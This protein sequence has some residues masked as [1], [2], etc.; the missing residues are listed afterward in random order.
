MSPMGVSGWWPQAWA[1]KRDTFLPVGYKSRK[2]SRRKWPVVALFK[3]QVWRPLGFRASSQEGPVW[4]G[5]GE[6]RG[7]G[8]AHRWRV[9][10]GSNSALLDKP[11][12][13][14]LW[15]KVLAYLAPGVSPG[16]ACAR[17]PT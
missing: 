17:L 16:L 14:L 1:N 15:V 6:R 8:R 12:A 4:E 9:G 7:G 10:I 11:S 5:K 3:T 2:A 13:Q